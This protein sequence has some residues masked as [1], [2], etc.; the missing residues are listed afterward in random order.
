MTFN[1]LEAFFLVGDNGQ[2]RTRT[3]E[4]SLFESCETILK[5]KLSYPTN[6]ESLVNI[7]EAEKYGENN[8]DFQLNCEIT[9]KRGLFYWIF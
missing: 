1:L 4:S 5:P 6:N 2:S 3:S 8:F 7:E 9:E